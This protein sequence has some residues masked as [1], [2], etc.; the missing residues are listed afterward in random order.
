MNLHAD[1]EFDLERMIDGEL[2]FAEQRAALERLDVLPDGWRRLALG[3]LEQQ[4]FRREFQQH[5]APVAP[6]KSLPVA[7]VPASPV[8]SRSRIWAKRVAMTAVCGGCLFFGMQIE[9]ARGRSGNTVANHPAAAVAPAVSETP[10]EQ[11]AELVAKND[12]TGGDEEEAGQT[13]KVAFADW[14][15]PIEVPVVETD[16]DDASDLLEQSAVSEE[17]RQAWASAGYLI[18]E[19][20]KYV[21]VPLGNGREGIAPI[22]DIVVE[23]VGTEEYQ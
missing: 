16:D 8:P 7:P 14:P 1:D 17:M 21:P 13:M 15:T 10:A 19:D 2:S 18:H 9:Q 6:V 20:R 22:S 23:Y 11:A 4:V 3:L 12:E 5:V